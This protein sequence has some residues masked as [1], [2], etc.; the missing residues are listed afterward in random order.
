MSL[1]R[2]RHQLTGMIY[3]DLI[4]RRGDGILHEAAKSGMCVRMEWFFDVDERNN[5]GETPLHLAVKFQH[6]RDVEMLLRT[7]ATIE[8]T[9]DF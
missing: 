5:I 9:G 1:I 4:D 2:R 3:N 8:V 6:P 7:G